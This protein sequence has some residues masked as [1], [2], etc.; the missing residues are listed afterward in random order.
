MGPIKEYSN[1]EYWR[2]L[3]VE[4]DESRWDI[5]GSRGLYFNYYKELFEK[6]LNSLLDYF[7]NKKV[8]EVGCGKGKWSL[9]F[10]RNQAEVLATDINPNMVKFCKKQAKKENLAGLKVAVLDIT[11]ERPKEKYDVIFTSTVLQHICEEDM[12]ECAIRNMVLSLKSRGKIILIETAAPRPI[13]RLLQKI[14]D[15]TKGIQDCSYRSLS[16]YKKIFRKYGL[17]FVSFQGVDLSF[18]LSYGYM[19]ARSRS[20]KNW[21]KFFYQTRHTQTRADKLLYRL[22][23]LIDTFSD[24]FLVRNLSLHKVMI[25]REG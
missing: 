20:K 18:P 6:K 24:V 1:R 3:D 21:K 5:V 14:A 12:F 9:L 13:S 15:K 22:F 10:A 16:S 11:R 25:F 8:L 23:L 19:I 4:E 17:K 7:K 2:E